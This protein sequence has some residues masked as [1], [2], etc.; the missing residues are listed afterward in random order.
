LLGIVQGLAEWFP[1]SSSGHF[2]V[3]QHFLVP[4]G[5]PLSFDIGLHLSTVLVLLI[6]FR[7]EVRLL[8]KSAADIFKDVA[9]GEKFGAAARKTE[10]RRFSC[11]VILAMI[12]T[13]VIGLA[14]DKLIVDKYMATLLPVGVAFL[15]QGSLVLSTRWG[16]GTRGT[17]SLTK[18]DAA[19]IGTMQGLSALSGLSR[20]GS[21]ISVGM[22]MGLDRT[23]AARFSFLASIPAL[24]AAA[25]LHVMEFTGSGEGFQPG[26][27]LIGC[28]AAFVVGLASLKGLMLILRGTRFHLFAIY[29]FIFGATVLALY[30]MGY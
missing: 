26:M 19:A 20:S 1:V 6:F 4:G 2:V 24:I 18:K 5:L 8:I 3:L 28:A 11:L 13:G 29:S 22:A 15:F 30:F 16:K 7:N 27:L 17:G 9:G 21:T 23:A 14:V 25:G 10:Y 12:P